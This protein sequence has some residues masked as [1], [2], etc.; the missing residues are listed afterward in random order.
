MKTIGERLR[1]QRQKVGFSQEK[2][3]E[4]LNISSHYYYELENDRK[5][6]SL[7]FLKKVCEYFGV[8]LDWLIFGYEGENSDESKN[9][10]IEPELWEII[11]DMPMEKQK[12]LAKTLKG[13]LPYIKF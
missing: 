13:I 10:Q 12:S 7:K 9:M 3:A 5:K 4:E 2:M 8:S 11:K 6:M 1:F